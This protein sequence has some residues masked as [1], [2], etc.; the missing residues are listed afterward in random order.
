MCEVTVTGLDMCLRV[1]MSHSSR[2]EASATDLHFMDFNREINPYSTTNSS[3]FLQNCKLR[4]HTLPCPYE[5]SSKETS[6]QTKTMSKAGPGT[7]LPEL[8]WNNGEASGA[9]TTQCA[10]YTHIHTQHPRWSWHNQMA[11]TLQQQLSLL[12]SSCESLN[13]SIFQS[14]HPS[15]ITLP[16]PCVHLQ[17]LPKTQPAGEGGK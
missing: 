2:E 11:L 9:I 16:L 14:I 5:S 6:H 10:S 17:C 15:I 8:L 7:C 3:I 13:P 1:A 12:L 4:T